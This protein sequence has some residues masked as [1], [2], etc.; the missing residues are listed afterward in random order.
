MCPCTLLVEML[1]GRTNRTNNGG[2]RSEAFVQFRRDDGFGRPSAPAHNGR[3]PGLFIERAVGFF[4]DR[5][6]AYLILVICALRF[7]DAKILSP[8]DFVALVK[9]PISDDDILLFTER[10][11]CTMLEQR[12]YLEIQKII[13]QISNNNNQFLLI[14]FIYSNCSIG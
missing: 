6:Y 9:S 7:W 8:K 4:Q 5:P 14:F 11:G 13:L 3:P 2:F 10:L 1:L 12:I